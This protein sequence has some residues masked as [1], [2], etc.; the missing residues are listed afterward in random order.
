M[1]YEQLDKFRSWFDEYV[2]TFYGEDEFVNANLKLKE[3]HSKR[4]R[5]EMS[6]LTQQLDLDPNQRRIAEAIALFHDIGRFKQFAKYRTYN[7]F[8]SV[9]HN[10]LA[11]QVLGEKNVLADVERGE[12]EWIEKAIEYHGIKELPKDLDGQALLFSQLIRDADKLD[13]F[14]AVT[15]YY[16]QYRDNPE[17]FELEIEYP[18]EPVYTPKVFNAILHGEKVDYSKLQTWNDMKLLQLGWVYD[19]N[20]TP[21]LKRIKERRFLEQVLDFLPDNEDIRKLRKSIFDYVDEMIKK[22]DTN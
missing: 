14:Y 5:K 2:A 19:V 9:D 15:T 11:L 1:Q 8:T 22:N 13:I 3:N 6:Y 17:A 12:R 10:L 18:D 20:F 4:V 16:R 21:T 7:D